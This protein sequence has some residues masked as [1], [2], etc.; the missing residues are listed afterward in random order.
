VL[1]AM[2]LYSAMHD[3]AFGNT[4]GIMRRGDIR[5]FIPLLIAAVVINL[6]AQYSDYPFKVIS[7]NGGEVFAVGDSLTVKVGSSSPYSL[8]VLSVMI[9]AYGYDFPGQTTQF[10]AQQDTLHSFVIPLYFKSGTDSIR[11]ISDECAI[12]L[13]EYS[14]PGNYDESDSLFAIIASPIIF[15]D[16]IVGSF[17]V[18]DSVHVKWRAADRIPGC[19]IELSVDNGTTWNAVSS[20]AI[21]RQSSDWGYF[22]FTIPASAA[23]GQTGKIQISSTDG[24]Y[25]ATSGFTFSVLSDEKP[26]RDCGCGSGAG[27]A[28]IPWILTRTPLFRKKKR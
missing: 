8:T 19:N 13:S 27:L 1:D 25:E 20:A 3:N 7:P 22:S 5:I 12:H 18:G 17:S 2:W 10:V 16:S 21:T 23:G 6:Q 26:S 14:V 4:R 11:S 28:F 24:S 9:G 15:T